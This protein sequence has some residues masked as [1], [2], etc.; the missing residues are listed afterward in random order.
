VAAPQWIRMSVADQ[1]V[2]R[3]N[4]QFDGDPHEVY[5]RAVLEALRKPNDAN[6]DRQARELE[7]ALPNELRW[8]I[9]SIAVLGPS[10]EQF[11]SEADWVA[12]K[13]GM[14]A[15]F[16]NPTGAKELRALIPTH[17]QPPNRGEHSWTA[18]I[19]HPKTWEVLISTGLISSRELDRLRS[20]EWANLMAIPKRLIEMCQYYSHGYYFEPG[21]Q[22]LP[23]VSVLRAAI[24]LQ[25]A[26][27]LDDSAIAVNIFSQ[28]D[29]SNLTGSEINELIASIRNPSSLPMSWAQ[30]IMSVA[31]CAVGIDANLLSKLWSALNGEKHLLF[32]WPSE[33]TTAGIMTKLLESGDDESLDLAAA[34]SLRLRELDATVS[35]QLNRRLADTLKS[36]GGNKLPTRN[37]VSG[38]IRSRPTISEAQLYTDPAWYS[39]ADRLSPHLLNRMAD[40]IVSMPQALAEADYLPLRLALG[41]MIESP[42]EYPDGVAAAAINALIKMD[43]ASREPLAESMWQVRS[44]C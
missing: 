10:P 38:L 30:I 7:A 19:F 17:L 41:K 27:Q 28:G 31:V 13:T 23:L 25:N 11:N 29:L 3:L 32:A 34:I 14:K 37:Q 9:S 18:L 33:E 12:Y 15:Y 40:K 43:V 36:Y 42:N 8:N 22:A 24:S 16:D 5:L 39:A 44:V 26:G 4:K 1:E 20:R 35:Q 2:L 6:S 21:R